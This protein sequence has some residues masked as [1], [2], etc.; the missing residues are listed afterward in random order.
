MLHT[1]YTAC[2]LYNDS[3][4]LCGWLLYI[5]GTINLIMLLTKRELQ[6]EVPSKYQRIHFMQRTFCHYERNV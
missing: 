4:P 3:F 6:A 5:K 2:I 1:W